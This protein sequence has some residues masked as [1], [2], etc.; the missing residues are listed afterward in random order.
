MVKLRDFFHSSEPQQRMEVLLFT[1][2]LCGSK[3]LTR[4]YTKIKLSLFTEV[5]ID[6][7]HLRTKQQKHLY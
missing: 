2:S 1:V 7:P 3:G 4:S 6:I 5:C